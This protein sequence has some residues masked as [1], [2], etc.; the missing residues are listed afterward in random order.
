MDA[1][2]EVAHIGSSNASTALSELIKREVAVSFPRIG[3]YVV[4]EVPYILGG[5]NEIV[6]AVCLQLQGRTEPK[7]IDVGSIVF[8]MANRDALRLSEL[9]QDKAEGT[10]TELSKMDKDALEETGNILSGYCLGAISGF[11]DFSIVESLPS[12]ATDRVSAVMAPVLSGP[13]AKAEE[14]L[15]FSTDF[16]IE[17]HQVRAQFCLVLEPHVH[18]MLLDSIHG[19]YGDNG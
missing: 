3:W 7:N 14:V 8:V 9:L 18:R 12:V 16:V 1:L 11:L 6:T 17:G 19:K 5:P 15:V 13:A 4:D 2:R 10:T